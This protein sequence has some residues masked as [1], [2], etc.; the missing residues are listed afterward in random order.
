MLSQYEERISELPESQRRT[1]TRALELLAD[2]LLQESPRIVAALVGDDPPEVG[3]IRARNRSRL[4]LFAQR[5][6][7]QSVRGSELGREL[8]V[9][10]QRLAQLRDA[11]RLLAVRPPLSTE[12]WYPRWQLS[13]NWEPHPLI[14]QLLGAAREAKMSPLQ[15]HILLTNPAAGIDERPL[16]EL[17]DAEPEQVIEVIAGAGELGN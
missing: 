7:E 3:S 10:R 9:S 12:F 5:V 8:G 11:D 13:E 16:V 4:E 14:T 15:L 17:L 6:R 2:S 1:Y